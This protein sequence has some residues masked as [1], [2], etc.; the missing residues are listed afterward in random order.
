M[1]RLNHQN[2]YYLAGTINEEAIKNLASWLISEKRVLEEK[3]FLVVSS[4]G[5]RVAS[6]F[7]CVDLLL[8]SESAAKLTTVGVGRVDSMAIPIFLAGNERIISPR[9][10]LFFHEFCKTFEK[11][12]S[13]STTELGKAIEGMQQDQRVYAEFVSTRTSGKMSPENVLDLMKKE[14][15]IN[16]ADAIK[17]GLAHTILNKENLLL[18]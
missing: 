4:G 16:A 5:G 2:T 8:A 15:M 12:V 18:P 13:F 3:I 14:T 1:G 9:T 6:G 17:L 10:N 11:E 7:A